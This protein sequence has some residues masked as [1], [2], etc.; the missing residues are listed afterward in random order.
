[1]EELYQKK[2]VIISIIANSAAYGIARGFEDAKK[3]SKAIFWNKLEFFILQLPMKI[4][5]EF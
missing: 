4:I 2:V 1:M 5:R 3:M